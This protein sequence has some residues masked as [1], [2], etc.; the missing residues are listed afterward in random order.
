MYVSCFLFDSP[1]RFNTGIFLQPLHLDHLDHTSGGKCLEELIQASRKS[2]VEM[3]GEGGRGPEN[4]FEI[5][6]TVTGRPSGK[7]KMGR[8]MKGPA[9]CCAKRSRAATLVASHIPTCTHA[10]AC[11]KFLSCETR[12]AYVKK[13]HPGTFPANPTRMYTSIDVLTLKSNLKPQSEL[14]PLLYEPD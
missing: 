5:V 10:I 6:G 11:M 4:S 8:K 14:H 7:T 9:C 12:K 3:N 1:Y 13:H 2:R